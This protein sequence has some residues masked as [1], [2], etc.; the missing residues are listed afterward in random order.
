ML[1]ALLSMRTQDYM[2]PLRNGVLM[3]L[4]GVGTLQCLRNKVPEFG[5]RLPDKLWATL[6]SL[7]GSRGR[8]AR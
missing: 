1:S 2:H 7:R 6:P 8:A 4:F 5:F 3:L